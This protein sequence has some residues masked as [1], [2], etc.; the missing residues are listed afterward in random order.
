M[1]LNI[2]AGAF[3][4]YLQEFLF[5]NFHILRFSFGMLLECLEVYNYVSR[6]QYTLKSSLKFGAVLARIVV[7]YAGIFLFGCV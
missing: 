7:R 4:E 1:D 2:M 5:L 3:T 6:I